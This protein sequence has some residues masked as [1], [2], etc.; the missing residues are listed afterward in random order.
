MADPLMLS[1]LTQRKVI[2]WLGILLPV[3][4]VSSCLFIENRPEEWCYSLS[5]T[6]HLSPVLTMMLS[7]TAIFLM[8]YQGYDKSD[9]RINFV[10]GL[11]A[12]GVVFFPCNTVWLDPEKPIGL[13]QLSPSTSQIV[14]NISAG[15][16]FLSF[17]LNILMQFT[18]GNGVTRTLVFKICGWGMVV[19]LVFFLLSEV[20]GFLP[21]YFTMI[22]ESILL[23]LFGVA[24]LVKGKT[25]DID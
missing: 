14:H 4:C 23:L 11:L 17:S 7:C 15:L 8:T 22:F 1:Y 25:F 21:G 2:G 3:L 12:L 13:F 18:K 10:S 24:W 16:L 19:C 9:R 20:L 5:A 6:Y